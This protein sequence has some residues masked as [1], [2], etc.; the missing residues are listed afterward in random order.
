[1]HINT[2]LFTGFFSFWVTIEYFSGWPFWTSSTVGCIWGFFRNCRTT[3]TDFTGNTRSQLTGNHR[4]WQSIP[5]SWKV[6]RKKIAVDLVLRESPSCNVDRR[7]ACEKKFFGAKYHKFFVRRDLKLCLRNILPTFSYE[8][9]LQI[10]AATERTA[11]ENTVIWFVNV[12][13]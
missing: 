9:Q 10:F 3:I 12:Y 4:G 13:L 11:N 7:S 8:K 5:K 6:W 2:N 1:M